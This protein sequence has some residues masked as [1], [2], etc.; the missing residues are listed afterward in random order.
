MLVNTDVQS[1]HKKSESDA[2]SNKYTQSYSRLSGKGKVLGLL[3]PIGIIGTSLMTITAL[4]PS[5]D[6]QSKQEA[7]PAINQTTDTQT[8][9][10]PYN[11]Y[12]YQDDYH[13]YYGYNNNGYGYYTPDNRYINAL[14]TVAPV[15]ENYNYTYTPPIPTT[16]PIPSNAP[17]KDVNATTQQIIALQQQINQR[18]LA[19]QQTAKQQ[20]AQVLNLKQQQQQLYAQSDALW[21]ESYK[22]DYNTPAGEARRRQ[23]TAQSDQIRAQADAL[24]NTIYSAEN[25]FSTNKDNCSTSIYAL[26][27]QR[28]ELE[29]TQWSQY[30][31]NMYLTL[32]LPY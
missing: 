18:M 27:Q 28:E 25:Q 16:A 1:V 29:S 24:S 7:I 23:L 10:D 21:N 4:T 17:T 15:K 19:C 13:G 32:Y 9:H 31:E 30:D 8:A 22:Q 3:L 14:P 6:V 5:Q 20:Q 11:Y 2:Y 12:S 26:I